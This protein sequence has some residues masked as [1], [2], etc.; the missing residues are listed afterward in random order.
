M[1]VFSEP[2]FS[3]MLVQTVTEGIQIRQSVLDPLGSQLPL[4]P[5]LYLEL[6]L[7]M[8]AAFES[9]LGSRLN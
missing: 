3:T 6:L 1:C 2:Q 4:G 9:C 5:N 8:A 7:E